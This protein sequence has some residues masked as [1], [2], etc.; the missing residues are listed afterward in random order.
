MPIR[1]IQYE[2]SGQGRA[3]WMTPIILLLAA[4]GGAAVLLVTAFFGVVA[5]AVGGLV[6]M[7][8]GSRNPEQAGQ[9]A[10]RPSLMGGL[11]KK[12]IFKRMAPAQRA[13]S[14]SSGPAESKV[15]RMDR[16][17]DGVWRP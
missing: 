4:L 16:G 14:E 7:F 17:D 6:R 2:G 15:I 1:M 5:L 11:V 8:M 13:D 10:A 12:F 3:S 9:S